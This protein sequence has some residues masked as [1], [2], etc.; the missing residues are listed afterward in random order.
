MTQL[1][2]F[3]RQTPLE[4]SKSL[5]ERVISVDIVIKDILGDTPERKAWE[6]F[7]V[8]YAEFHFRVSRY[9]LR[10]LLPEFYSQG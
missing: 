8:G 7:V 1:A 4:A 6:S 2:V 9:H 3:K 10:D 5:A